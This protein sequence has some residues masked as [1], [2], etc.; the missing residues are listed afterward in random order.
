ML[1]QFGLELPKGKKSNRFWSLDEGG[2]EGKQ[3]G[4]GSEEEASE[5]ELEE[6]QIGA[7]SM[8]LVVGDKNQRLN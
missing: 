6:D 1:S 2:S 5:G 8:D 3:E 4:E 7:Y